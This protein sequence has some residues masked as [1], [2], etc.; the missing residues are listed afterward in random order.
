MTEAIHDFSAKL[1]QPSLR[2]PVTG[3]LRWRRALARARAL[4]SADPPPPEQVDQPSD[5]IDIVAGEE[6]LDFFP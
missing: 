6:R 5:A 4:G 1:R 3:Y 2:E